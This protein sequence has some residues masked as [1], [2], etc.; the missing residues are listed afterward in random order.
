MIASLQSGD[1]EPFWPVTAM[2]HPR[3]FQADP[4]LWRGI[5]DFLCLRERGGPRLC[6]SPDDLITQ[7][8]GEAVSHFEAATEFVPLLFRNLGPERLAGGTH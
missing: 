6:E 5:F 8:V 7:A 1:I 2:K 4:V 3:S